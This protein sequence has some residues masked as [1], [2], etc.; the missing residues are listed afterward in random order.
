MRGEHKGSPTS[1]DNERGTFHHGTW[2]FSGQ[3]FCTTVAKRLTS[4]VLK[5][6]KFL[7]AVDFSALMIITEYEKISMKDWGTHVGR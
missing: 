1:V 5:E 7:H 6:A 3:F 2:Y 4:S